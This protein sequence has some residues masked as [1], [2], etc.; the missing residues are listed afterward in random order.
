[1][2]VFYSQF[3]IRLLGVSVKPDSKGTQKEISADKFNDFLKYLSKARTGGLE[4][5]DSLIIYA[6]VSQTSSKEAG[7]NL[8][9]HYS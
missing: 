4:C 3:P 6:L 9:L 7:Y 2:Y 8:W 5:D 1:M